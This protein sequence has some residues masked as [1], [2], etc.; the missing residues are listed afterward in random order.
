MKP[1]Q[2]IVVAT[3]FSPPADLAV[4][5]AIHL[6]RRLGAEIALVHAY[7]FTSAQIAFAENAPRGA[8]V[9]QVPREVMDLAHD[10]LD[11]AYDGVARTG[12]RA[13]SLLVDAPPHEG[14]AGAARGLDADLVVVGSHGRTGLSRLWFGSVAE[15]TLR[16]APC[17][18]LVAR[19]DLG[20]GGFGQI[21]VPTDFSPLSEAAAEIAPTLARRGAVLQHVHCW[22]MPPMFD[23]LG[24][25]LAA[26]SQELEDDAKARGAEWIERHRSADLDVSFLALP[27]PATHAIRTHLEATKPELVVMGSHGRRGLSRL[28]VG[29]VAEST[30]R[31][32]PCSVLVVRTP[33][34]PA[35]ET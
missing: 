35:D 14:I 20:D 7:P 29:S 30:V 9:R 27:G 16:V 26:L 23:D 24:V 22:Q 25:S 34:S 2:R 33:P 8:D 31:H 28:V 3:D 17:S 10:R 4:A 12:I 18:V 5:Q 13:S 32:A 21:V 11:A 6:A 1:F 19:S 15:K